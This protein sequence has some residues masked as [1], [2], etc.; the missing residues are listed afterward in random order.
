ML[1]IDADCDYG[2]II[3]TGGTAVEL[4]AGNKLIVERGAR[5]SDRST[6]RANH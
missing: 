3:G 4:G 5:L 1:G 6:T 2:T